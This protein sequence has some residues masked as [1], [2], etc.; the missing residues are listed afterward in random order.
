MSAKRLSLIAGAL[1]LVLWSSA[2]HAQSQSAGRARRHGVV[3]QGRPDGRRGG[4]RQER[5]ARPSPSASRPTT[6]AASASR[7]AGWSPANT[8]SALAPS[9][10]SSKVPEA[11]TS[12]PGRRR[13]STSSSARRRTCPSRCPMPNG[14]RAFPGTDQEKKA[15]LN[16]VSCHNLDRIVRSQYDAEQFV[17]IFNR[18]VGYYPGS[19]PEHPQRLV[20]N[21][22]RSLGQ[23]DGVKA[24]AEI[25]RLDQSEPR[26]LALPAQDAAAPDRP[27]QPLHRHGIRP[28]APA[29]PAA[30]RHRRRT[31]HDLVHATSPSSSS[32]RWTPRPARSAEFPDSR[33]QAGLSGR[34]ARSQGSTR[35]AIS[36]SA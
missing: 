35:P 23:G 21:A 4:Q 28:A 6:R 30:R 1:A 33:A 31:G 7:P 9:A 36:G 26:N 32:A 18:M 24:I 17:D 13:A 16:C 15:I 11:P 2:S 10:T 20:G 27:L 8:R 19:T 3:R 5:Q 14:S 12:R 25:S 34:H 22:Q 29:N